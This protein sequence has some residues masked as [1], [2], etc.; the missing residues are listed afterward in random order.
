MSMFQNQNLPFSATQ[1]Q[2]QF[3]Q[4]TLSNPPYV[5]DYQG[6]AE[7]VPLVPPV[8]AAMA[9][10]I[11]NNAQKNPLRLFMFNQY[12]QNNFANQ[13]FA[14][15]VCATMD[16]IGL[17]MTNRQYANA[18]IA[19]QNCIPQMA[20]MLCAIN[21]RKYEGLESFLPP[22]MV[23]PIKETIA[24][25]DNI[26]AAINNMRQQMAQRNN[27]GWNQGG[28]WGQQQQ[29]QQGW[30][31]A[32]GWGQPARGSLSGSQQNAGNHAWRNAGGTGSTLFT[33]GSGFSAPVT[34]GNV[35]TNVGGSKYNN[36]TTSTLAQPFTPRKETTVN[37][38]TT[39]STEPSFLSALQQDLPV[40]ASDGT[41]KWRPS[42]KW[43]YLPAYTPSTH[44]LYFKQQP[45]GAV[46]PIVLPKDPA[47]MDYDRHATVTS[48]GPVPKGLDLSHAKETMTNI[49]RGIKQLNGATEQL[50]DD[51]PI[52]P[53]ITTFI[54]KDM[55]LDTCETSAWFTGA[56]ERM[57]APDGKIPSVYRI[58]ASIGDPLVSDKDETA[59]VNNFGNS[60]T[61]IE[62]REKMNAAISEVSPE[63]WGTANLKATATINR[64]VAQ[65]LS[66]PDL[67]I[68]SF[69]A[70]IEDLITHLGNKFG[71]QIQSAFLKH[72]RQ[73][74]NAM[75]QNFDTAADD[76]A[77]Q[78]L[79]GRT[80]AEGVEPKI[81]F[82]A[83]NYSLTYL[84]C[85]SHEL[86]ITVERSTAVAVTQIYSPVMNELLDGLF[87]DADSRGDTILRHLIRTN[88]GRILEATRGYIAMARGSD[89]YLLTL[90][91]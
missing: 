27:V 29:Q 77:A 13:D 44:A 25:F 52:T 51:A 22:E 71:D 15:A 6:F 76:M 61:F 14:D 36:P 49:D 68:D 18:E 79:E 85:M 30:G 47:A 37:T 67:T 91:K 83:S 88:D 73:L 53:E 43:P 69:V 58:Y 42:S 10:E 80:Y 2:R 75:F 1:L 38:A 35:G 4:L 32:G 59:W 72:Q 8:A 11:Q 41:I 17:V 81:T 12:S 57:Q 60:N 62:L 66:I 89:F 24:M 55:V 9:M 3:L 82:M 19:A 90:I 65:N 5:P 78:F 20:E 33:G 21:L 70:D 56:L 26:A 31:N 86:D 39:T 64:V 48:F 74:I 63:L 7:L 40:P 23:G 84:N 50:A 16:Y 34:A 46:E 54:K 87:K 45:D 28:G